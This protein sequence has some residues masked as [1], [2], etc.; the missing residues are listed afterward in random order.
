MSYDDDILADAAPQLWKAL[1]RMVA[2][3]EMELGVEDDEE[4]QAALKQAK[5]ALAKAEGR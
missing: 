1:Q 2:V 5:A 3:A 4:M